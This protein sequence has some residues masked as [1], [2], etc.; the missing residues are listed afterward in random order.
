MGHNNPGA[1]YSIDDVEI[2]NVQSFRD[3]GIIS[4]W[5]FKALRTLQECGSEGDEGGWLTFSGFWHQTTACYVEG[6]YHVCPADCGI[7]HGCMVCTPHA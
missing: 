6:V 1:V 3:L 2:E 4:I 7:L 5:E